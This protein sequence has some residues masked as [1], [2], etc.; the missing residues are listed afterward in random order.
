MKGSREKEVCSGYY[1]PDS[2]AN[3]KQQRTVSEA[4]YQQCGELVWF[5]TGEAQVKE[6]VYVKR[7]KHT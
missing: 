6:W 1:V 7:V 2:Q 3:L 5:P 4:M